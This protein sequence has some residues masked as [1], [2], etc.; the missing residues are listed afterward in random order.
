MD[1]LL[2][3]LCFAGVVTGHV[4]LTA[5]RACPD[6]ERAMQISFSQLVMLL[7]LLGAHWLANRAHR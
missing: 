7:A 1:K 3:W 4:I 6:W 2:S 5:T